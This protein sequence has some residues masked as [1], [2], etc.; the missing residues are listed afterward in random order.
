MTEAAIEN[1][2]LS[3]TFPGGVDIGFSRRLRG[4][5]NTAPADV[6]DPGRVCEHFW[7]NAGALEAGWYWYDLLL[8]HIT[9]LF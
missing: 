9:S 1:V 5:G 6:K 4:H 3:K 8:P 7:G 2:D